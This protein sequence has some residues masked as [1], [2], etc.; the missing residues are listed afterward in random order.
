MSMAFELCVWNRLQWRD[1]LYLFLLMNEFIDSRQKWCN[2]FEMFEWL[3]SHDLYSYTTIYTHLIYTTHLI[4]GRRLVAFGRVW[5]DCYELNRKKNNCLHWKWIIVYCSNACFW[6]F[7]N[8][9]KHFIDFYHFW[10]PKKFPFFRSQ[11]NCPLFSWPKKL[12]PIF[13]KIV[14]LPKKI[15]PYFRTQH[16]S[17]FSKQL[18]HSA[19]NFIVNDFKS[20]ICF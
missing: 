3:L 14:P 12:F 17:S 18:L 10:S 4:V 13:K 2:F 5:F 16:N 6:Y 11:K 1:S 15:V 8:N 9:L 7:L 20:S 19:N